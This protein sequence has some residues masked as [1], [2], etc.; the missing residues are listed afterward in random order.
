M[1]IFLA[2]FFVL[3]LAG[4]V[5]FLVNMSRPAKDRFKFSKGDAGTDDEENPAKTA[6][7]AFDILKTNFNQ[8]NPE[9]AQEFLPFEEIED[10]MIYVGNGLYRML[11][12]VSSLNYY[13]RTEEEQ[14]TVEQQFR[15]A[16]GGWYFPWGIYVQTREIDNRMVLSKLQEEIDESTANFP[17]LAEYSKD[18]L[19]FIETL[20]EQTSNSLIKK[21]Y[22]IITSD[23]AFKLKNLSDDE[24]REYALNQCFERA[25]I[26][27][28]SLKS[29]GL[30]AHICKTDELAEV[31]YIAINKRAGGEIDGFIDGEFLSGMVV[32]KQDDG[33]KFTN[34]KINMIIDEFLNKLDVE[35][36]SD[37]TS[38]TEEIIRAK[39]FARKA[40]TLMNG[41]QDPVDDPN[42]SYNLA[43]QAMNNPI[44]NQDDAEE[45]FIL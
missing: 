13:L 20:P 35:V 29:M 5:F 9:T 37:R 6:K 8:A 4:A 38:T 34:D 17:R 24:R 15:R 22:I 42:D 45:E 21:K 16:I 25:N 41:L 27:I 30:S 14:E 39:A 23:D 2:I 10:S 12:E 33:S 28:S 32:G 31:M 1:I 3:F 44:I 7:Q 40:R 19:N 11:V 26:V 18:Y 43:I 36:A